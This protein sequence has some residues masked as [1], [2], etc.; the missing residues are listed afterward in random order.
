MGFA[1]TFLLSSAVMFGVPTALICLMVAAPVVILF[2]LW[3]KHD[4]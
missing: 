1:E 2:F 3:R 4:G